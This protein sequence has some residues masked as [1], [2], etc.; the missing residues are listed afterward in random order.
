[1]PQFTVDEDIAALVERLA[2]RLCNIFSVK[3]CRGFIGLGES[4]VHIQVDFSAHPFLVALGEQ[5]RNEAQAGRRIGEDRSHAGSAFEF[6]VD[7]FQ[8]VGRA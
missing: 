8:A 4:R 7:A 3:V 6:A 1:M 2:K 5:R